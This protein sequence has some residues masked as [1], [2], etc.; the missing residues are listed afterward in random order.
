M[1]ETK[2]HANK[3][4]CMCLLF[5]IIS[6]FVW[7]MV[8]NEW[9]FLELGCSLILILVVVLEVGVVLIQVYMFCLL[10]II[11]ILKML[12]SCVKNNIN[13]YFIFGE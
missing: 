12:M 1:V 6:R 10:T 8:I 11:F 2:G 3:F 9:L 4:S 13:I 5:A 7:K